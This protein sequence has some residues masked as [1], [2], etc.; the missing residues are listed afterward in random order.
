MQ[1]FEFVQG[2]V[3]PECMW[4]QGWEK[5]IP[6]LLLCTT[7]PKMLGLRSY[8]M[9]P[10]SSSCTEYGK[11]FGFRLEPSTAEYSQGFVDKSAR[12]PFKEG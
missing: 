1:R 2:I 11:L 3:G 10:N 4:R 5:D 7:I 8:L 6:V 12:L 9:H